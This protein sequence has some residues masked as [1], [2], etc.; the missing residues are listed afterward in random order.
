VQRK[1]RGGG[2][3]GE[4]RVERPLKTKP[5]APTING[6]PR[7][8]TWPSTKDDAMDEIGLNF[9]ERIITSAY[10]SG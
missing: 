7:R 10:D 1:G 4:S 3:G 2:G 9:H 5:V 8:M 6:P